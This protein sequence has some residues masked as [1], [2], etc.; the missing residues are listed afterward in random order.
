MDT[1]GSSAVDLGRSVGV[2]EGWVLRLLLLVRM[3]VLMLRLVL[4]LRPKW[5]VHGGREREPTTRRVLNS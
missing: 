2:E 1:L 4:L 5:V 3:R